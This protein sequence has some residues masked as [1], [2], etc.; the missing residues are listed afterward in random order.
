M[1]KQAI[2]N[3]SGWEQRQEYNKRKGGR[4]PS[5]NQKKLH[6]RRLRR[7]SYLPSKERPNGLHHKG[8]NSFNPT[9]EAVKKLMFAFINMEENVVHWYQCWRK[10]SKN[11]SWEELTAMLLRRFW[12]WI[13]DLI[14]KR[15]A[16]LSQNTS[17]NMFR[18]L[19]CEVGLCS[20]STVYDCIRVYPNKV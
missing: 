6:T 15:L 12:G 1:E 16:A 8:E 4:W 3:W 11:P 10:V 14:Y 20:K 17:V 7:W 5:M 2:S 13:K 19:S 18:S 9:T